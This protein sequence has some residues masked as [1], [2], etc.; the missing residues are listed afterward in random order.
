MYLTYEEY[1]GMGGGVDAALYPPL[2]FSARKQI[3]YY[4]QNRVKKLEEVPEDV[5][6]VM[7]LL[8]GLE[9]QTTTGAVVQSESNAGVSVSYKVMDEQEK[10]NR[11]EQIIRQ[12]LPHDLLYLGVG[13]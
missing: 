1:Q 10:L 7:F 8:I 6:M 11:A 3:D 5:Q 13:R 4:T 9:E 12:G 2:E